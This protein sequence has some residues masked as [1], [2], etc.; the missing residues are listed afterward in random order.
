[1]RTDEAPLE[2]RRVDAAEFLELLVS[3]HSL[4]RLV[5]FPRRDEP[6]RNGLRNRRTGVV[7]LSPSRGVPGR[8]GS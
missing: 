3:R 5:L 2:I 7:Y 4:E 1:M 6:A 8:A